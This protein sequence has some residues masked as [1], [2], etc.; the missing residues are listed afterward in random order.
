[1]AEFFQPPAQELSGS[2]NETHTHT[3]KLIFLNALA[4]QRLGTS[5]PL[6]ATQGPMGE[7]ASGSKGPTLCPAI[8]HWH[9]Y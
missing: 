9:L 4:T 3:H 1:M 8:G 2:M 7:V 5:N 6:P